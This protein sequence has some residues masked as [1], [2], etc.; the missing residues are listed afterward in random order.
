MKNWFSP[1]V[2]VIAGGVILVFAM[3]LI[4]ASFRVQDR[5]PARTPS[6]SPIAVQ[7]PATATPTPM[8]TLVPTIG[9]TATAVLMPTST[10]TPTMA[11]TATLIP[12]DTPASTPTPFI[13]TTM[14]V[15]VDDLEV[16]QG[17]NPEN[18]TVVTYHHKNDQELV[19]AV[20]GDWARLFSGDSAVKWWVPLN[21][22]TH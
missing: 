10:F 11:P 3:I 22:L 21:A 1:K 7:V 12:T 17:D 8:A 19:V 2:L 18:S 5:P 20:Q 9:F 15:A 16:R 13:A 4:I 6:V 14:F